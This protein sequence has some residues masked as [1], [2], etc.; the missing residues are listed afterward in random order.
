MTDDGLWMQRALTIA[1]KGAGQVSPNPMVGC[2]LVKN[3]VVIGEGAHELYG[4][5][6]AE[7][8]AIE[9]A[10]LLCPL[11]QFGYVFNFS[12]AG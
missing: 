9:R 10:K 2:V 11:V 7:T 8:N 12:H 4:G 3:G 1:R 6:H 5:A